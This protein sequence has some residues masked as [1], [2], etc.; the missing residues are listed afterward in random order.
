MGNIMRVER[1]QIIGVAELLETEKINS[2][3]NGMPSPR[4]M[5]NLFWLFHYYMHF[6][7]INRS[8]GN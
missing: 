8:P 5:V 6:N 1:T 3:P 2:Y 4:L 7:E